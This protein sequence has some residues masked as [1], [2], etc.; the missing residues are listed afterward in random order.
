MWNY[1]E[2]GPKVDLAIHPPWGPG[3]QLQQ[4]C[5]NNT[6]GQ[7][8]HDYEYI[9]PQYNWRGLRVIN[10][11]DDFMFVQWDEWYVFDGHAAA[12][13]PA[14]TM[15]GVNIVGTPIVHPCGPNP[16]APDG[17]VWEPSQCEALCVNTTGCIGWVLHQNG[18]KG[19]APGWRCCLKKTIESLDHADSTTTSGILDP[20]KHHPPSTPPEGG[21]SF[22]EFYDIRAGAG[23]RPGEAASCSDPGRCCLPDPWQQ[24][25]LWLKSGGLPAG[26]KAALEAEIKERFA[27]TGTRTHP[28]NCE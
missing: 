22:A 10:A 25:N 15:S 16:V 17:Y 13:Q 24:T 18:P 14:T 9:D 5:Q 19:P 20:A 1:S 2:H 26:R 11:T 4:Q 7:M 23:T 6:P 21:I 28:S 3:C 8:R 12:I 27:C